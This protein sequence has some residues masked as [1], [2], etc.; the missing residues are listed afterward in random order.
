M[1]NLRFNRIEKNGRSRYLDDFEGMRSFEEFEHEGFIKC[2][3]VHNNKYSIVQPDQVYFEVGDS[4]YWIQPLYFSGNQVNWFGE[5][6]QCELGIDISCGPYL[7][8]IFKNSDVLSWL[9][10]GSIFYECIIKGPKLLYR[11]RTGSAKIINNIPHLKLYHHTSKEALSSIQNG[12]EYWSSNWNIQGTKQSQNISYLYLTSLPKISNIDDL[13]QIAMSSNGKLAFRV[14]SNFSNNPDLIL[15]VYRESTEN[16]THTL[17]HW[18]KATD[19]AS[20]PC[21]RHC[22]PNGSG[23]H[24][25]VSPFIQRLGV[26]FGS[27]VMIDN[28]VLIPNKPKFLRYSVIGEATTVKGLSAPYDEENTDEKLKIEYMNNP[29]EIIIFWINNSNTDQFDNKFIEEVVF[30]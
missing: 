18:V 6:G 7:R 21:Y 22:P 10:D 8:I 15:D 27:T 3:L 11:Y 19:L 14:D 9:D 20:Q 1:K 23:Y 4:L 2:K 25:V 17:S 24:A 28:D 29:E 16:R 5:F 26:E 13:T 12:N 30:K